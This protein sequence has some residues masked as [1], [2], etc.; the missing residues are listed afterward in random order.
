[1]PPQ[2]R[3]ESLFTRRLRSIGGSGR[4]RCHK[5]LSARR[6]LSTHEWLAF[7]RGRCGA[8]GG[9]DFGMNLV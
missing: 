3:T 4:G 5:L 9:N 6:A 7:G 2:L 1:M 8:E